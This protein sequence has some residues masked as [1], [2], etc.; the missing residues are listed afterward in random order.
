M[1]LDP[2]SLP[3]DAIAEFCK[4]NHILRLSVFGSALRDD[5]TPESDVDILVEFV[6]ENTPG[7]IGF[8]GIQIELAEIIGRNV[9]LNTVGFLHRLFRAEVIRQSELLY[10]AA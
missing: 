1:S 4:R 9:D 8:E 5:F 6:Q 2:K 7:M 10:A 3:L